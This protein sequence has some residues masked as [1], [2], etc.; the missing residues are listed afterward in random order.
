MR[1]IQGLYRASGFRQAEVTSKLVNDYQGDPSLLAIQITIKEGP[2]TRV[3]WVRIEGSYTL[4]A[5]TAARNSD[6]R[7]TG[8]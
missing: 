2:Q 4:P 7:K 6:R 3:A 1:G 8:L 5:G